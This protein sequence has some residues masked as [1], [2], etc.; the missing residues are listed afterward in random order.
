MKART[1]LKSVLPLLLIMLTATPAFARRKFDAKEAFYYELTFMG[2]GGGG[3]NGTEDITYV[4]GLGQFEF[5]FNLFTV[6]KNKSLKHR[7]GITIGGEASSYH[8][9]NDSFESWYEYYRTVALLATL[10]SSNASAVATSVAYWNFMRKYYIREKDYTTA[11]PMVGVNYHFLSGSA[12]DPYVGLFFVNQGAQYRRGIRAGFQA[13][14]TDSIYFAMQVQGENI[15][16]GG[17]VS[18][19]GGMAGFGFRF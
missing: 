6:Y 8:Y 10:Q 9:E 13:D 5:G 14:I 3:S 18:G 17:A 1:L 4:T 7:A 2:G 15:V 16:A 12:F 19:G 11:G